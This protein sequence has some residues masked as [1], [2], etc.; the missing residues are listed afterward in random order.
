MVKTVFVA[1]LLV[2][3]SQ[4]IFAQSPATT[5][6]PVIPSA[7]NL[8]SLSRQ[9]QWVNFLQAVA[10][11]VSSSNKGVTLQ[12]SLAT[13]YPKDSAVT[14]LRYSQ[15][16]V[17]GGAGHTGQVSTFTSGF[18]YSI[19]N[20]RDSLLHIPYR[21]LK[22]DPLQAEMYGLA[23][24]T[25]KCFFTYLDTTY[26]P[27]LRNDITT[28]LKAHFAKRDTTLL[29]DIKSLAF[30]SKLP[31]GATGFDATDSSF[32][33]T[34]DDSLQTWYHM[35]DA[36]ANASFATFL[37]DTKLTNALTILV[38][39][40]VTATY[41]QPISNALIAY[42][43]YKVYP[44]RP[45]MGGDT[46]SKD[47]QA[48]ISAVNKQIQDENKN[49]GLS[50]ADMFTDYGKLVLQTQQQIARKGLL[51]GGFNYAYSATGTMTTL[52]PS[53]QYLKGFNICNKKS[54]ESFQNKPAEL[55]FTIAD[56]IASD[57]TL[58]SQ[59]VS[60]NIGMIKGA[61]DFTLVTDATSASL[62]EVQPGLEYDHIYGVHYKN[63]KWDRYFASMSIMGRPSTKSPWFSVTVKYDTSKGEFF[64]FLDLTFA[65]PGSSSSSSSSSSSKK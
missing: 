60:R 29:A 46:T 58:K 26:S 12:G 59:P 27:G 4:I 5:T 48:I 19:V 57:S 43:Y 20:K 10:N 36:L 6:T 42:E 56:S 61:F 54:R 15:L 28:V 40:S 62:L 2:V 13:L 51:I 55:Q 64:G 7:T 37:V 30:F 9:Q 35:S 3:A 38:E 45:Y 21:E 8:K 22:K 39:Y 52:V 11:N 33:R 23:I 41:G 31:K 49:S 18:S 14:F 34:M 63:E 1:S 47:F 17:G 50:V 16:Q 65:I 44:D 53:L 25:S 32:I 24:I